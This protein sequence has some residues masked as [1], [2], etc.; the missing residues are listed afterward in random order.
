MRRSNSLCSKHF[1][2]TDRIDANLKA[3]ALPISGPALRRACL[4]SRLSSWAIW[5]TVDRGPTLICGC[6]VIG[7]WGFL[8]GV[9][10]YLSAVSLCFPA[11][12]GLVGVP[13]DFVSLAG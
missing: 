2:M 8:R 11:W 12:C 3:S 5:R 7:L 9:S 1:A 13:G 10:G 6:V 4:Y